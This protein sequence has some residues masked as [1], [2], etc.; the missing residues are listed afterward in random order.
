MSDCIFCRI[1]A[2]ELPSARVCET[3]DVLAFL[4]IAPVV[5]G[6]TLVIPKG[7]YD[8]MLDTPPDV[9][10]KVIVQVRR[11]ARALRS[12]LQTDGISLSQAN[13]RAAG[14]VV[15]HVHFHLI[16]RFE[17]GGDVRHW[18]AGR[19]ETPEEMAAMCARIQSALE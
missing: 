13:G 12:A 17:K 6:H 8:P 10:E 19:Y 16:P 5:K 7:H 9:L 2:A 18:T 4:D 15:P 1:V 14:Q 3:A 11:V